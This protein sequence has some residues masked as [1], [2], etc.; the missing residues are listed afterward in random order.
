MGMPFLPLKRQR[1][2][3]FSYSLVI[4]TYV[5]I[6]RFGDDGRIQSRGIR[7]RLSRLSTRLSTRNDI[8]ISGY[9]GEI[10]SLV[11]HFRGP[12][13]L[14]GTVCHLFYAQFVVADHD[15]TKYHC[16]S[17]GTEFIVEF[18]IGQRECIIYIREEK[19]YTAYNNE[20]IIIK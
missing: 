2:K 16:Y 3:Y 8:S 18:D 11:S 5:C 4:F 9:S 14:T 13:P 10:A 19:Y 12:F 20:K 1:E 15:F 7:G 17:R 6:P